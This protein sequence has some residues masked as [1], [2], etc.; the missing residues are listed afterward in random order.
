MK[1]SF[2]RNIGLALF[3]GTCVFSAQAADVVQD[4]AKRWADAYN[5]HNRAQLG[6]LYTPDAKLM[7]HGEPTISGRKAIEASWADDFKV[8][9]PE[10]LLTVTNS[11]N[12]VDM[13]LVHG[14]YKVMD[15]K[16]RKELGAGR[17][18]HIWLRDDKGNWMLDRDLWNQPVD[19]VK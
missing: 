10:T 8:G 4:L 18:A 14:N 19:K 13:V 15:R 5:A 2:R 3:L 17:F 12:G 11:V 6:A 16:T 1:Q 7:M 9:D